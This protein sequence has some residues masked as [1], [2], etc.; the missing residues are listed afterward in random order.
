VITK[1]N[2]K[3]RM[4]PAPISFMNVEYLSDLSERL[5]GVQI[6]G[7]P[8]IEV[9]ERYDSPTTLFYLDPPYP[10]STRNRWKK[11][12]YVHE[13]T[14]QQHKELARAVHNLKGMTLIS[15]YKCPLYDELY[16]GWTRVEKE[17]RTNSQRNTAI[18]SLWISPAADAARLPL[19][20]ELEEVWN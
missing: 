10:S 8:A 5:R 2:N 17:A 11:H 16:A 18:E 15:S 20:Q 4:T 13:M 6:E 7:S 9:I 12:A 14:D 1:K 3:K 19:F